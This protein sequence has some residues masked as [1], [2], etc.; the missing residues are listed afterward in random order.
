MEYIFAE[1]QSS[2][3]YTENLEEPIG[4]QF[5]SASS[6]RDRLLDTKDC[7]V[8]LRKSGVSSSYISEPPTRRNNSL[9]NSVTARYRY[10]ET[11]GFED[12]SICI[13]ER[14]L[15]SNG[16]IIDPSLVY[17]DKPYI[18]MSV[19]NDIPY[20]KKIG[21]EINNTVTTIN[22]SM[23]SVSKRK[24]DSLMINRCQEELLQSELQIR[25]L[26]NLKY[27]VSDFVKKLNGQP[28]VQDQRISQN[29]KIKSPNS[30][31]SRP[32]EAFE[33][34]E[35]QK[36]TLKPPNT[37]RPIHNKATEAID[38]RRVSLQKTDKSSPSQVQSEPK[39]EGLFRKK[40]PHSNFKVEDELMYNQKK[41]ELT[42]MN[43]KLLEEDSN[44]DIQPEP[45][46]EPLIQSILSYI[47]IN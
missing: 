16:V 41:K 45:V 14:D 30:D 25:G 32:N 12:K 33:I 21:Q 36:T 19:L 27:Q 6:K 23:T 5:D 42:R 44:S 22:T 46:Q 9:L 28:N 15:L 26:K 43:E 13:L 11:D 34:V 38:K 10:D 17:E 31:R 3:Y 4:T 24:E 7:A 29:G 40:I 2:I 35:K 18:V 20:G 47:M 1:N 8:D 39:I 37:D